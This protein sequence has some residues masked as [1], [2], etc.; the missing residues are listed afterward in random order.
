MSVRKF[1]MLKHHDYYYYH[2]S[3]LNQG[4]F[5]AFHSVSIK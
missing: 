4:K 2:F 3:F 5:N 1:E